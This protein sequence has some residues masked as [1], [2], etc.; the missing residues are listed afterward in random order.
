MTLKRILFPAL[1]AFFSFLA[2][3][4]T[5][6]DPAPREYEVLVEARQSGS[7]R[8]ANLRL[9]IQLAGIDVDVDLLAHDVEVFRIIYKTT[10]RDNEI[11]ASGLVVM[12]K[13]ETAVP[14]ISYQRATTVEQSEAPSAQGNQSEQVLSYSALASLGYITV[15]PDMIGFGDSQGI[16]HPYY[17]EQP[18]ADAVRDMLLAARELANNKGRNF[19]GQLFL[20]GYSQG[21]YITMA[22]HKALETNPLEG[23]EVVASF[24]GAGGYDLPDMLSYLRETESY[25]DPY[26]FAYIALAYQSYYERSD[27]VSSFFNE[28]YASEIPPLF[29]GIRS[30]SDINSELTTNIPS[31]VTG[32]ILNDNPSNAT[33]LFIEESFEANSP[34]DWVPVAPV[35]MYHGSADKVVPLQNSQS[36]YERLLDN[37]GSADNIK[38]IVFEGR[39][40][41]SAVQPFIEDVFAKVSGGW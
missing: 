23:F 17:V 36:T 33:N 15:V 24:S 4:C 39:T 11:S 27:L 25:P 6:D 20:A 2:V 3:S 19:D 37:G 34:I 29:D 32:N 5:H 16:F 22:A 7:W 18:S 14:M 26:Y 28:P 8:A 35:F 9:L 1:L 41:T 21:G 31:L 38:L 12:P 13:T 10:Y 30:G 40:H